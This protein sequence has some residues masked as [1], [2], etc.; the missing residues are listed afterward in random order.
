MMDEAASLSEKVPA[1]F[2]QTMES[3]TFDILL[4]C[5]EQVRERGEVRG[6]NEGEMRGAMSGNQVTEER[7]RGAWGGVEK[8]GGIAKA[9]VGH[10]DTCNK[11]EH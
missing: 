9:G 2:L 6:R 7:R 3:D 1:A 5:V 8:C 11:E 4:Q 10:V